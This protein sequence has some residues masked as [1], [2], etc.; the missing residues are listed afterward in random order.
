VTPSHKRARGR[1]AHT[2]RPPITRL[3]AYDGTVFIGKIV[4]ADDC[5]TATDHD[6]E[7]L[8]KFK[9]I[10]TAFRAISVAWGEKRRVILSA[11]EARR[12]LSDRPLFASGLPEK[13]L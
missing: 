6:G 8:G 9:D 1:A 4:A 5:V 12:R 7:P 3:F 13:F 2:P 11:A 10:R